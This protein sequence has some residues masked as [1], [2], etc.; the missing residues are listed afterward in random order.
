MQWAYQAMMNSFGADKYKTV[1]VVIMDNS[2]VPIYFIDFDR[3]F[4]VKWTGPSL[5][6]S[7]SAVAIESIE[8]AHHGITYTYAR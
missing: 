6:S 5:K 4:P 2:G 7:D 3:A 8:L 1:T